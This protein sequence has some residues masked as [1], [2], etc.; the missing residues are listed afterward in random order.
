MLC[1]L[2][3]P[4]STGFKQSISPVSQVSWIIGMPYHTCLLRV[5]VTIYLALKK[6]QI[7]FKILG[8]I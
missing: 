2:G 3:W 6:K 4:Q 1:Y 5:L 8:H 7:L